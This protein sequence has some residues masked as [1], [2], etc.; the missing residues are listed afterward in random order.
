M[1]IFNKSNNIN[2]YP[3]LFKKIIYEIQQIKNKLKTSTAPIESKPYKVYSASLTQSGTNAPTVI[4]LENTLGITP[5]WTRESAGRYIL[6]ANSTF[7][8]GKTVFISNLSI[9]LASYINIFFSVDGPGNHNN[10]SNV[11]YFDTYNTNISQFAD[12]LITG[13]DDDFLFVEIRV[14]N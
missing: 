5:V 9:F 4:I 7:T 1:E 13:S 8:L 12:S 14:Y 10:T 3:Q 6:T 11:I 2:Y